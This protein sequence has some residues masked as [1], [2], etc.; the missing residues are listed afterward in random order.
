MK[1]QRLNF[2]IPYYL[3][4]SIVYNLFLELKGQRLSIFS[5]SSETFSFHVYNLFL[6]LK[7]QRL[8][9]EK[10]KV[11]LFFVYN[12][13]LELKG[14]RRH[15]VWIGNGCSSGPVYNLFLELKG[16]RRPGEYF[17]ATPL[18]FVV[19]NLFLELKGQRPKY[20]ANS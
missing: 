10:L 13:F 17:G 12:L 14:Q 6:E 5:I 2:S 4:V 15:Q 7:G 20:G 19:Y 3:A 11:P 1:G 8:Q 16:Q 18:H 9:K